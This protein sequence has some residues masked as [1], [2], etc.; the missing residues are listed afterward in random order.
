M[1]KQSNGEK[2]SKI[3]MKFENLENYTYSN[4]KTKQ[5]QNDLNDKRL[6][7]IIFKD[8]NLPHL[9]SLIF[10]LALPSK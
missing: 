4:E 3:R 10:Q 6:S 1:E 2:N 8:S 7:N 5:M 9:K